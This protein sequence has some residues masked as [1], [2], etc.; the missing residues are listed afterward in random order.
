[1]ISYYCSYKYTEAHTQVDICN[2][3]LKLYCKNNGI[4]QTER[5]FYMLL[6]LLH[7]NT[8]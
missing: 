3:Y 7:G 8:Q 6:L 2:D 4:P 5:A 1:M